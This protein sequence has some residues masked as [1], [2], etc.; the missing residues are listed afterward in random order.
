M[1]VDEYDEY[2]D[3]LLDYTNEESKKRTHPMNKKGKIVFTLGEAVG[4]GLVT[5]ALC[6]MAL[7]TTR[8][9]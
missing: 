9:G 2:A 8:R 1:N 7:L 6:L 4:V 3:M 5:V